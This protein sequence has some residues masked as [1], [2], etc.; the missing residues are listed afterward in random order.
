MFDSRTMQFNI[1]REVLGRKHTHIMHRFHSSMVEHPHSIRGS[2]RSIPGR[3]SSIFGIWRE[4]LGHNVYIT[5]QDFFPAIIYRDII[6]HITITYT[7]IM[8]FFRTFKKSRALYKVHNMGL[9]Y[10]KICISPLILW[11]C[12]VYKEA[13]HSL[14]LSTLVISIIPCHSHLILSVPEFEG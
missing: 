11:A 10:I 7:Y 2:P 13:K 8:Y 12:F 1:W 3:Y 5:S 4:V 9:R 6:S 14:L